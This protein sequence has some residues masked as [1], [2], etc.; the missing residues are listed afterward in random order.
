MTWTKLSDDFSD[1]CWELSDAAVR[2]HMEGLVWSNR[3]LLDCRLVKDDMVRWA[4]RPGAAEELVNA[5][6]WRDEGDYYLI[7]HH[8][9]YQR[10]REVMLKLQE[11]NQRN[12]A[13][14]GRPP[15]VARERFSPRGPQTETQ[16][17]CQVETQRDGT[18]RDGPG[19]EGDQLT[20]RDNE[21]NEDGGSVDADCAADLRDWYSDDE[22]PRRGYES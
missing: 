20:K 2:L 3:K 21:K 6:W 16:L 9:R 22:S 8:A 19:R 13:S 7:V 18:G 10:T 12:G 5:G 11:R 14:G 15:K 17:G 1:D 4:K